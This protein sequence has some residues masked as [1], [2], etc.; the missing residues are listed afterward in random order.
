MINTEKHTV[1][2]PIADYNNMLEANERYERLESAI[3]SRFEALQQCGITIEG[4]TQNS[5][6]QVAQMS[7]SNTGNTVNVRFFTPK[8]GK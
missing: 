7:I 2:I 1:T 5:E 3:K 4:V 6:N 8:Y